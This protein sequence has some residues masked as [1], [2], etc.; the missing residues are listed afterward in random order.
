[1]PL[2]MRV[3]PKWLAI[4]VLASA[5]ALCAAQTGKIN[6]DSGECGDTPGPKAVR[7]K[8]PLF[9]DAKRQLRAYGLVTYRYNREDA[10]AERC[11][12]SLH[13]FVSDHGQP[14]REVKS[15]NQVTSP[16]EIV[17]VGIIGL[18]RSGKFLAADF[19]FADGDG[20]SHQ[21]VVFDLA[22]QK[23]STR[24]LDPGAMTEQGCDQVQDFV[25]VTDGGEAVFA[26][27]PSNYV[28]PPECGDHGLWYF[29]LQ[30]GKIRQV[31]KFSGDTWK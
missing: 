13:L 11:S 22:S 20:V 5:S 10:K 27:P 15:K 6:V 18:S 17:G 21:P 23:A 1:M 28:D 31:K 19:W 8:S 16:G 26:V 29:N 4:A 7:H 30:S 14:F 12:T 3:L 2:R 24:E 9:V 25:G